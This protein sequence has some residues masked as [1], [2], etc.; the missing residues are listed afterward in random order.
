MIF[1]DR[2]SFLKAKVTKYE[3]SL[4]QIPWGLM[5]P[6]PTVVKYLNRNIKINLARIKSREMDIFHWQSKF[7]C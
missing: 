6:S 7:Y 2:G 4:V 1:V 5:N 3:S